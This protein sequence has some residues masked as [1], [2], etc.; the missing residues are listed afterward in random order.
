[1]ESLLTLG[2]N[3]KTEVLNQI[4]DIKINDKTIKEWVSQEIKDS[5]E[6]CD[7]N[8]NKYFSIVV[9]VTIIVILIILLDFEVAIIEQVHVTGSSTVMP[10]VVQASQIF[11]Q[12]ENITVSVTGGG[13]G[14][15][16]DAVATG[17]SDI[18]MSSRKITESEISYYGDFFNEYVIAKDGIAVIVSKEIYNDVTD[19][20]KDQ[21]QK[22][23]VGEITNWSEVNGPNRQI[24]VITMHP[25]S[26]TRE[27]FMDVIFGDVT[28]Q[29]YKDLC[30]QGNAAMMTNIMQKNNAIGYISIGY[31]NENIR[32]IAI[33]GILPTINNIYNDNYPITRYL[34]LYTYG[35]NIS[36]ATQEFINFVLGSD[37]QQ[38]V[39]E[40]G[41]VP[42]NFEM[43]E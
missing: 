34:Y 26:G 12:Q 30:V 25:G 7:D 13:S 39:S 27:I 3:N 32:P 14:H 42:V 20:T 43:Y 36:L 19:L 41:Y 38:I 9:V 21:I 2:I 35:H 40:V 23:F 16:I 24:A 10:I 8:M 18:G 29:E 22:I 37:G 11:S 33:D 4:L 5:S 31:L 28:L 15:G 6:Q 17:K 1:M